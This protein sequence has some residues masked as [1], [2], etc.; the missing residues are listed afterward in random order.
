[1]LQDRINN[2]ICK[3]IHIIGSQILPFSLLPMLWVLGGCTTVLLENR[4]DKS[5][6]LQ[7]VKY[8]SPYYLEASKGKAKKN[9]VVVRPK[10]QVDGSFWIESYVFDEKNS[11]YELAPGLATVKNINK[12]WDLIAYD[13]LLAERDSKPDLTKQGIIL[14]TQASD[15]GI[16]C[17]MPDTV[18]S[19]TLSRIAAKHAIDI[20]IGN[21]KVIKG[22]YTEAQLISFFAELSAQ[23]K[24]KKYIYFLPGEGKS[25]SLFKTATYRLLNRFHLKIYPTAKIDANTLSR[26]LD[27]F[28]LLSDDGYPLATVLVSRFYENGWGVK[29]DNARSRYF[30]KRALEQGYKGAEYLFGYYAFTGSGEEKDM[31]K[32]IE[33]LGLAAELGEPRAMLLLGRIYME[34]D[35]VEANQSLAMRW[36]NKAVDFGLENAN[37]Y[38]GKRY[39]YGN[40]V[41]KDYSKSRDL[42]ARI[43]TKFDIE[44]HTILA[45]LVD[46][47]KGGKQDREKATMM[48]KE[49]A[50]M[51]NPY[52]Q[53]QYGNRL[54]KGIG[55]TKN[56]K[57]GKDWIKRAAHNG[58]KDAIAALK[59][60]PAPALKAMNGTKQT[61]KLFNKQIEQLEV[62][63][64]KLEKEQQELCG[65]KVCAYTKDNKLIY[66]TETKQTLPGVLSKNGYIW[67]YNNGRIAPKSEWPK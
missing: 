5:D 28:K 41:S 56:E 25:S 36:L 11:T 12:K 7:V 48:Y 64:R 17:A 66:R 2:M 58:Q 38:L 49:A 39:Y 61:S 32:A 44:A 47:G 52:A 30:A 50:E 54:V 14:I 8:L 59:K 23:I 6:E 16:I 57:V 40:D 20:S 45:W 21:E 63:R 31:Q 26:L 10:R 60:I 15:G 42:L 35:G 34:G 13:Y 19:K 4:L 29:K 18:H 1:M 55:V 37:L 65:G 62:I 3:T 46:N 53:W 51:A 33:K 24:E 67:Y 43:D 27:Y 9:G 22:A